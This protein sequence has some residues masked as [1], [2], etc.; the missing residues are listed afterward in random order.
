VYKHSIVIQRYSPAADP[1]SLNSRM[2]DRQEEIMTDYLNYQNQRAK[3]KPYSEICCKEDK[4]LY[5]EVIPICKVGRTATLRKVN[6]LHYIFG[7]PKRVSEN[8]YNYK[9]NKSFYTHFLHFEFLFVF[10]ASGF[11]NVLTVCNITISAFSMRKYLIW[12]N[13][14]TYYLYT[15]HKL[16]EK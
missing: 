8:C 7:R 13:Y 5:E 2:V 1:E 4:E 16:Y 12:I 14:F 9:R 6:E 10:I 11:R 3:L 15:K